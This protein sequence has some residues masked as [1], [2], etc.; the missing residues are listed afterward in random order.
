MTIKYGHCG[1][2]AI[3]ERFN[4]SECMDCLPGPKKWPL[5]TGGCCRQ[6]TITDVVAVT[7][8]RFKGFFLS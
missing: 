5:K 4:K 3:R 6:V 8:Q 2:A 7:F 1:E